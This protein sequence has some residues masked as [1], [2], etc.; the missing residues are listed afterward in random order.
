MCLN[1]NF[2]TFCFDFTNVT[3]VAV[4]KYFSPPVRG[5]T[6]ARG[7]MAEGLWCPVSPHMPR[8][9]GFI[10]G[11][12]GSQEPPRFAMTPVGQLPSQMRP[13]QALCKAKK[14]KK[15]KVSSIYFHQNSSWHFPDLR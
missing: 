13:V 10:L 8:C 6:L 3:E 15:K 11:L 4:R 9:K 2:D 12:L 14:K 1:G 5:W 7:T